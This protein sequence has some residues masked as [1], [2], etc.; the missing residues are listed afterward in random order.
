VFSPILPLIEDSLSLSHRAAGGLFT[1]LAIGFSLTLFITGRFASDWGYKR[2]VVIGFI[3]IALFIFGLQKAESYLAFHILFFVLG[4]CSGTYLPCILPIITQ[5]YE[6][7]HW[8]KAIGLHETAPSLSIFSIPILVPLALHYFHWKSLLLILGIVPLLFLIPFWKVSVEPKHEK[9]YER[10]HYIDLFR[11]RT[12][13]IIGLL[14][15]FSAASSLGIYSILPLYLIKERGMDFGF[16]NTLLGISRAAGVIVPVTIGFL[17]D[18]YGFKVLLKWSIF[19]TG[20]STIG[21]ALSSTLLLILVTLILQ[22]LLC[23]AFFPVALI[24][25]SKLTPI[26]ERSMSVGFIIAIGVIFGMGGGPFILGLVAD[27]MNFKVGIF[28]LG[29]LTALSSL[30]VRFLKDG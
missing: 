20:L 29:V 11:N 22:A 2:M 21:L 1:S 3:G 14:W 23:L 15:I 9:I 24:A 6:P 4:V 30:M 10:S 19:A 13:W 17:T 27:H 7:R 18:R 16:A 25:I 28:G 8:S 12:V 5:T 26:S